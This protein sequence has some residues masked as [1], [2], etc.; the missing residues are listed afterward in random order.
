MT[1]V[2]CTRPTGAVQEGGG[3]MHRESP[4]LPCPICLS[5]VTFFQSYVC[6]SDQCLTGL[7]VLRES[8]RVVVCVCEL[9]L[10][11]SSHD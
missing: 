1:P 10:V 4:H 7:V 2:L 6:R 3:Q 8:S 5:V 11:V 9:P